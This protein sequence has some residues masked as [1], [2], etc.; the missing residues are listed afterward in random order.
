MSDK[1]SGS[2]EDEYSH[3]K[4]FN[5]QGYLLAEKLYKAA[6]S[7]YQ[8]HFWMPEA[9]ESP[10]ITDVDLKKSSKIDLILKHEEMNGGPWHY[11]LVE[12]KRLNPEYVFWAFPYKNEC[13]GYVK[14]NSIE[15]QT[16]NFVSSFTP[17]SSEWKFENFNTV[18]KATWG[19]S[20]R[21][22]AQQSRISN[23]D[24]IEKAA[25]QVCTQTYGFIAKETR[26]LSETVSS[27][28][29]SRRYF[30]PIIVTSAP[31]FVM[32]FNPEEID[33]LGSFKLKR[34]RMEVDWLI[35][36]HVIDPWITR[37]WGLTRYSTAD[38]RMEKYRSTI[39]IL[40]VN[41]AKFL[42]FLDA[43]TNGISLRT[44]KTKN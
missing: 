9:M 40:I 33:D 14:V 7:T 28:H 2:F 11:A 23:T 19:V 10:V 8:N 38:V 36:E 43:L 13:N 3:I 29:Y 5:E 21:E 20:V 35:Y 12:C 1:K 44:Q 17:F 6:Q 4:A 30:Y 32:G 24:E 15:N 37:D 18:K 25:V 39:D 31:L 27:E 26:A 42:D 22:K 34:E 41:S 16:K